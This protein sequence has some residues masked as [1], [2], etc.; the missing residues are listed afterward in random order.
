MGLRRDRTNA[1]FNPLFPPFLGEFKAGGHPQTP[2]RKYPAPLFSIP[3]CPPVLR[4]FGV[5]GTPILHKRR[6][7]KGVFLGRILCTLQS[8]NDLLRKREAA[9]ASSF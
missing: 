1:F 5:G 4:V 2:G 9:L 8:V 3:L 6:T 7:G